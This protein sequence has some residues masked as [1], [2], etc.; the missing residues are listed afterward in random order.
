M[1][2]SQST[3]KKKRGRNSS[4][5]KPP[6]KAVKQIVIDSS[7]DSNGSAEED[8]TEDPS[9]STS[10]HDS[11]K[12]PQFTL[13]A[14]KTSWVWKFFTEK[15][16]DGE[17]KQICQAQKN[18]GSE[19]LCL[20]HFTPD[21]TSSTKSMSRHLLRLHGITAKTVREESAVDLAKYAKEGRISK[22][23]ISVCHELEI[24]YAKS[25]PFL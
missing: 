1:A 13:T 5:P 17:L 23:C 8:S 9:T 14:K 2:N 20:Q 19:E 6:P 18:L 7:D 16:V 11:K 22:V 4:P 3:K 24:L 12:P 15:I 10:A 21:K 25:D